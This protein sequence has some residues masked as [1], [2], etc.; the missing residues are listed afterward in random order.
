MKIRVLANVEAVAWEAA[1]FIAAEARSTVATR[2]RFIMTVNGGHT[3]WQLELPAMRR[4]VLDDRGI[5][6]GEEEPFQRFGAALG[7]LN[8]DE[9]FRVLDENPKFSLSGSG[10]RITVEF[11]ENYR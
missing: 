4:L 2:G 1:R 3:P 6:T 7:D 5:P 9:G 11:V 8:L 10:R